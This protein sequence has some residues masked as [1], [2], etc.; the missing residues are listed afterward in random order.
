MYNGKNLK[1]IETVV[2]TELK[3]VVKWLR[4]NKLSLNSDKTELIFSHSQRHTLN[5]DGI[6]IKFDGKS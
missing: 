5:Y 3:E 6:S 2:N 4:L 1:T